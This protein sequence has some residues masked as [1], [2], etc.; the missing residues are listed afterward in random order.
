MENHSFNRVTGGLVLILVL[1]AGLRWLYLIYPIM[2]ADQAINGVMARHILLGEFPLFFYG[3]EYCG[4]LENYLAAVVFLLFGASRFTLGLAIGLISLFLVLFIFHLAS[5]ILTRPQALVAALLAAV[6]SGYFAFTSVLARSAYIETPLLGV[7]LFIVV[8]RILR[9]ERRPVFYLLT[10]LLSGLGLWTHFLI[11]FYLAPAGLLLLVKERGFTRDP[12]VPAILLAGALL[13]G[14]PLWIYNTIH[15]LATWHFLQGNPVHEPFQVSLEHFFSIRLPELLGVRDIAGRGYYIPLASALVYGLVLAGFL[16]LFLLGG[17]YLRRNVSGQ[18]VFT[19]EMNL[20]LVLLFFYPWIFSFSGFG[21]ANTTRYL[22]P[23]YPLI[24][25][26][27]SF[28]FFQLQEKRLG[29]IPAWILLGIFLACN[30]YGTYRVAVV[31]QPAQARE[32]QRKKTIEKAV[33]HFLKEKQIRTVYVPDYWKAVPLTFVAR[34]EII[35]AQPL[36]DR[37]P[38]YTGIVDRSRRPAYLLSGDAPAF[39]ATLIALG[40]NYQKKRIGDL[41]IF[42]DFTPPPYRYVPLPP[43]NWQAYSN[44]G[45]VSVPTVIDR[46]LDTRWNL[47]RIMEPGD[48]FVLDLGQVVNDLGRITLLAG[49][50]EGLPRGLRLEISDDGRNWRIPLSIPAYWDSLVWSG[51]HPFVRPEKGALELVFPPQSGR[52]LKIV[53]TGSD[54]RFAWEI[55]EILI[56]RAIPASREASPAQVPQVEDLVERLPSLGIERL[57]AGPWIAAYLPPRYRIEADPDRDFHPLPELE[58]NRLSSLPFPEFVVR[59]DQAEGLGQVLQRLDPD[60]YGEIRFKDLALFY[61][62]RSR[63]QYRP[64]SRSEWRGYSNFNN[65]EAGK[66]LDG[67]RESRWTSGTPQVP[68]VWFRLD[69]GRPEKVS[70]VR[71]RLGSSRRDFPRRLEVRVSLNGSDWQEVVPLNQPVYWDGENW[72]REQPRGETDLIFPEKFTRYIE[73]HQKGQDS[74][75]YWSIHETEVYKRDGGAE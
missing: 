2:D 4:S 22:V 60:L 30:A 23:L 51:P 33:I 48:T 28:L 63:E 1:A 58:G 71:L 31:F 6:P 64:L 25:V 27:I 72:F 57:W 5:R 61:T 50:R 67:K 15:P 59:K 14:L 56:Y 35:F 7:L 45:K 62:T 74:N 10:G 20:L 18:R 42:F 9:G 46:N 55:A 37:Y 73:F 13:G 26:S 39:E 43:E 75:Y 70:R 3:Q 52:Y 53:Q 11:V 49:T 36:L 17:K 24:P 19:P 66:A 29:R 21:A 68:G 34:E 32:Y 41:W 47:G 44:R 8:G 40:G 38:P 54:T 12:R 16:Y 65:Q 69:L